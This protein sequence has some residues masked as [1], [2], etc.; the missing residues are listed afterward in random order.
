[1]TR[2]RRHCLVGRLLSPVLV[3]ASMVPAVV[4]PVG[5]AAQ[6]AGSGAT[7]ILRV[8]PGPVPLSLG[9]AYS[10]V[11]APLAVEYNPAALSGPAGVGISYQALPVDASAGASIVA[12]EVGRITAA[13]SL[14]FVDY[15]SVEVVVPDP[16]V[17]VGVPTGE[18]AG[19]GE[20][21]ALLGGAISLGPVRLGLAGRWL[22]QDVAGLSD[23]ALAADAGILVDVTDGIDVGAS[24]QH[25]GQDIEAGRAAPLPRTVRVGAA[26]RH[27]LGPWDM[28]LAL[29]GRHREDRTGAGAGVE[30]G[31]TW[32][33]AQAALR[34]G[35][36]TRPDPGDAYSSLVIGGG[37]RLGALGVELAWR[38]LGPL[39][40]TRQLGLSYRF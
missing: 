4:L 19:G 27:R 18:R 21:S 16:S 32:D 5:L 15:G 34:F 10:A 40:T 39:G 29:E 6:G 7:T 1:M 9:N 17:P 3:A 12:F 23:G 38:S 35:Y 33:D 8:A 2:S 30:I 14:R 24:V 28:L 20:V 22:R 31:R 37:V 25:L 13:A 26:A 36:E 11:R